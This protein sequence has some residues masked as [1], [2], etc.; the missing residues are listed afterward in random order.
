MTNEEL[1]EMLKSKINHDTW[2][3]WFTSAQILEIQDKKVI[4]GIG[5]LFV[6]DFV[7]RKYGALVSNTLSDILSRRI[8]AEFTFIPADKS[9]KKKSGPL[10]KNRP[11]KLSDFNS[12]YTFD[13]FVIG[14]ANRVAYYSALE[15]ANNPGKYNPLFIYGDV[16]LGKTHLLHAIGNHL[17]ETSPDLKVMY[18]TAEEFM[19]DLMKSL[20]DEKMD[21]FRERY[22]KKIDI[23]LID[24]VQFLI[25]KDMAQGEL[26]HTFNTLFNLGKQIIICSDRTPEELATFHPRL[27]SR[28]EMGLVVNVDEPDKKTKL[29]IA[30]KMAEM[31]SVYLTDDVVTYL[32]ENID[33][34]LRRL[35]GLILNLFF[36]S[37]VTGEKVNIE[38]VKKLYS[39]LKAH[40]KSIP[41][42]KE[43]LKVLKKN[44][45]LEAVIK[46]YNLT[47]E[48][49]FS[50]TR[51][52]EISEARQILAFMLK[53]YGKMKVK[54]ISSFIGKN[55][56]TISQSI[57]KIEKELTSGN[58]ILKRR[59][60]EIRKMFEE[61]EKIQVTENVS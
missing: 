61:A 26:F 50:S 30:K 19:N 33:N 20:R 48:K 43:T 38:T 12:E 17:M 46:E 16:A 53:N 29:K 60:D 45:I 34:N 15:V 58:L 4:I 9:T 55:H 3:Q 49:L 31:S 44:L 11:L 13:N 59:I 23:L 24:D 1:L 57:K 2:E 35:R 32:V 5:N 6:K 42:T 18:V 47:R 25:G 37:K 54:D 10:I 56:S 28:F 40:K 8:S 21:D 41:Q 22:R 27:I 51:K 7:A 39:S 14:E 52:K 36:H